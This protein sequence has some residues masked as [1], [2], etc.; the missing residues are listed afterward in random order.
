MLALRRRAVPAIVLAL[1]TILIAASRPSLAAATPPDSSLRAVAA[2]LIDE[3]EHSQDAYKGLG[4]L[5]DRIGN[6]LSGTPQLD[7][8]IAWASARMRAEGLA[9]VH[10]ERCMVPVWVRGHESAEMLLPRAHKMDL[11]GLGMSIGTPKGGI[12]ADVVVVDSFPQLDT[13]GTRGIKGKIVLYDVPFKSYGETV[14]YRGAG[15]SRAAKYGAVAAFVRSITPVSLDTPHTGS[16]GYTDSLPKI[17]AAAITI[18]DAT[19]IHRLVARGV[20]VRV[21]LEMEA[22]RKPDVPSANVIGEVTGRERPDEIVA[23]GGH[24][25]SWDVGQGAQD[26]G[27]GATISMEAAHLMHRLG[28]VPRRTVRVVL[29]VN[30]ENGT[31]GGRAYRDAHRND[32]RHNVALIESDIGNGLVQGLSVEVEPWAA[33]G[34]TAARDTIGKARAERDRED[35]MNTLRAIVPMLSPIGAVGVHEGHAGADVGPLAATGVPA[36]GLDH[37]SSRYFDIHHTNADTFDKIDPVALGKNVATMAV[38]AYA[39]AEWPS[40]LRPAP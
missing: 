18:E 36:I 28:I 26:D 24:L 25:D 35:V 31:R 5:C 40:V 6:R 29:W 34:D 16:L 9:N 27:V 12:T 4:E 23:I 8:A 11:L 39:L 20:R 19:L 7:S 1:A 17:P 32:S 14:R 15:A 21:H 3:A 13:L 30:E 10:T 37:D 2:R 33:K 38:M 22:H